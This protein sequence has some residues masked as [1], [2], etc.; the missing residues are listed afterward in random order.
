LSS[1]HALR[2]EH[3]HASRSAVLEAKSY[4]AV[5]AVS[6][7]TG[8]PTAAVEIERGYKKEGEQLEKGASYFRKSYQAGGAAEAASIVADEKT[9]ATRV[10]SI[11]N[12]FSKGQL[13]LKAALEA[14][15]GVPEEAKALVGD[16]VTSAD[17]LEGVKEKAIREPTP[18]EGQQYDRANVASSSQQ[19]I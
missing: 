5:F 4:G 6:S 10:K 2:A 12:R 8:K 16:E 1:Y 13:Y 18:D 9:G 11:S 14:R 17:A 15:D 3:E 19:R 7:V